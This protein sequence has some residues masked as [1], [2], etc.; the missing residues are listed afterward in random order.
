M[1]FKTGG[2]GP[3]TTY[4]QVSW[5]DHYAACAKCREV[6]LEKPASFVN[7]CGYPGAALLNEELTRRQAPVVREKMAAVREW[8]RKAGVFKGA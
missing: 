3:N 5:G 7:A 2:E 8:A 6:D 4:E 1:K